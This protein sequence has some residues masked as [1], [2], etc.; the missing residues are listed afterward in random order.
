MNINGIIKSIPS[1]DMQK[2][3]IVRARALAWLKSGTEQQATTTPMPC[4]N[5][6]LTT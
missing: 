6:N 4:E 5:R 2:R 3:E 1:M